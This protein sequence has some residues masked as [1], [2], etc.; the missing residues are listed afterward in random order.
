MKPKK[1]IAKIV[2]LIISI[3]FSLLFLMPIIWS[4]A[5]SFQIEGSKKILAVD[6]FV[7][8]YTIA[9]YVKVLSNSS[10]STWL[11]NSF[12]IAVITLAATILFSS[13]AAY[14][15][16]KIPFKGKNLITLF[17]LIGLMVPGEATIV[18][19]FITA[20]GFKLIDTYAGMILPSIAG[21]MNLIIM[22]SFFEG[23]PDDILEAAR[24]D[25]AGTVRIFSKI[26]LPMSQNILVTI[27]IFAFL[28]SWNNYLWPLLC[29]MSES[30]FTIPIGIPTFAG[31]YTVD[32]IIPVT[33]SMIA[34][35]PAIIL[36]LIFEKYIVE[37]VATSGIKG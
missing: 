33:A 9:N 36:F 22:R 31:T 30:M 16:A 1:S 8:P 21:S 34:S 10:V 6:W 2:V 32:Y 25:G 20:N 17:F 26:V 13:L 29:A 5:A 15:I 27:S 3:I 23:I 24:I 7:P 4:I 19:L 12:V 18:P 14:A 28:G 35:I 11:R 37:G